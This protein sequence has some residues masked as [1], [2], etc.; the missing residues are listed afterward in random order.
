MTAEAITAAIH[1][2]EILIL[3]VEKKISPTNPFFPKI[4]SRKKPM[5]TGGKT[6][7]R[8]IRPSTKDL[9][10]KFFLAKK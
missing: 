1:V 3:N 9:P 4:I 5:T 2:K 7:G 8:W 6:K 10:I